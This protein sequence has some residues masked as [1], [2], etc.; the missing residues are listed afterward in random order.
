MSETK[1]IIISEL[2]NNLDKFISGQYLAE[3]A[4]V[5]R[6]AINKHIKYLKERGYD[7][8]SITRR[9]HC[10]KKSTPRLI[11]LEIKELLNTF[12]FAKTNYFYFDQ[13]DSTNSYT[14]K[15]ALEKYPEGTVVISE[16]QIKGRGKNGTKWNAPRMKGIYF[17]IILTPFIPMDK[18]KKLEKMAV[19]SIAKTLNGLLPENIIIKNET[20]I[21]FNEKK[22]AG[23]LLEFIGEVGVINSV[24]LGIGIKISQVK[25]Y[26]NNSTN[27]E[28]RLFL[29]ST[30]L[31]NFEKEYFKFKNDFGH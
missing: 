13:I 26:F 22:I 6:N 20:D 17:S 25:K 31:N 4:K 10:L 11:K 5:S 30:L 3:K 15:L 23:I 12:C 27:I 28:T 24:V 7:I 29:L 8:D 2:K 9:G 1:N 18:L 16:E 19:N 14:L 21:Y